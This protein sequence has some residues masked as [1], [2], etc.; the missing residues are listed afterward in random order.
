MPQPLVE[1]ES[2]RTHIGVDGMTSIIVGLMIFYHH[3][4]VATQLNKYFFLCSNYN[5]WIFVRRA[6]MMPPL[7][8]QLRA[9]LA[10]T[11]DNFVATLTFVADT[12]SQKS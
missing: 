2:V 6:R 3:P 4:H 10:E 1:P 7:V 12:S 5:A 9:Q 8:L 11:I